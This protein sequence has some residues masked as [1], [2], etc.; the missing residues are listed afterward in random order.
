MMFTQPSL[1]AS[2]NSDI[3]AYTHT[4]THTQRGTHTYR[5][6]RTDTRREKDD[7]KQTHTPTDECESLCDQ[8]KRGSWGPT[9]IERVFR[10]EMGNNPNQAR[11]NRTRTQVLPRTEPNMNLKFWVLSH[12]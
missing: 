6:T 5:R 4:H 1:D 3:K 12:L 2:T 7:K 8:A 9:V 10:L 11:T